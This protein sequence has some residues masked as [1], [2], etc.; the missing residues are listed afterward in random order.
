MFQVP[1]S[2]TLPIPLNLFL[3]DQLLV[4]KQKS[5]PKIDFYL[6]QELYFLSNNVMPSF[7][8]LGMQ[9]LRLRS[10]PGLAWGGTALEPS[11][12][13]QRDGRKVLNLSPI[14]PI[15]DHC[16]EVPTCF[17]GAVA[18]GKVQGF[19]KATEQLSDDN[20]LHPNSPVNRDSFFEN[21]PSKAIALSCF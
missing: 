12:G 21:K 14:V 10:K 15:R 9:R 7:P 13:A 2:N 19:T 20:Q 1:E 5:F 18:H 11:R 3:Q 16:L 17:L 8:Q 4:L 6:S